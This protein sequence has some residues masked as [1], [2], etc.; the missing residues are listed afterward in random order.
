MKWKQV[1][2]LRGGVPTGIASV[3]VFCKCVWNR[4]TH[5]ARSTNMDA[6][7]CGTSESI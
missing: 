4:S 2:E 3:A 7:R 6:S 1:G 5:G